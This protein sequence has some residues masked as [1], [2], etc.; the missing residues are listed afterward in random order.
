MNLEN[1]T[2]QKRK[3]N[4]KE[5]GSRKRKMGQRLGRR[6]SQTAFLTRHWSWFQPSPNEKVSSLCFL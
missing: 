6:F 2:F 4:N 3:K 5:L 1:L